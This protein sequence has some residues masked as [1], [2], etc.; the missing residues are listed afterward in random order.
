MLLKKLWYVQWNKILYSKW[1]KQNSNRIRIIF[2]AIH[3]FSISSSSFVC[4]GKFLNRVWLV[5]LGFLLDEWH[6]LVT[7][8][9]GASAGGH[10]ISHQANN[11]GQFCL[12][13]VQFNWTFIKSKFGIDLLETKHCMKLTISH[14]ATNT[15][16]SRKNEEEKNI[17]EQRILRNKRPRRINSRCNWQIYNECRMLIITIWRSFKIFLGL[18]ILV[19]FVV[20]Y[21]NSINSFLFFLELKRYFS[22]DIFNLKNKFWI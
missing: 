10:N 14:F 18:L 22:K 20:C 2:I 21:N 9:F 6:F 17:G 3:N 7:G 15:S 1:W 16:S 5:L 4:F 8:F 19:S 13:F 12:Q 11:N